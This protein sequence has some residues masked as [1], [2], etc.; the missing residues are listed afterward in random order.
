MA[1]HTGQGTHGTEG[2]SSLSIN[3][4]QVIQVLPRHLAIAG[5]DGHVSTFDWQTGTVHSELQLQETC[6]DIT[7][8]VF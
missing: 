6:R 3:E 2:A 4:V 1:D 5:R 7:Y 8:D